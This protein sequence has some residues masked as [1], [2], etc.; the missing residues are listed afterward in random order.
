MMLAFIA[1]AAA[2]DTPRLPSLSEADWAE[3]RAGKVLLHAES[4]GARVTASGVV[5][6]DAPPEVLWP[7]VLDVAARIPENRTL[8]AVHEYRRDGPQ[9]W[10]LQVDMSVLGAEVRIHHQY[11]WDPA[12]NVATYTLDPTRTNDLARAD[13]WYLVRAAEGGAVLAYEA[14]TEAKVPVPGWVKKWLARDQ[15]EGLLQGIRT[16]AERGR[17]TGVL[18]TS[19]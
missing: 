2:G 8:T 4:A 3:L 14:V 1:V 11:R 9:Q 6:V 10:C 17:P 13:G 16:R 18:K 7:A 15:L 5:L 12:E 19:D